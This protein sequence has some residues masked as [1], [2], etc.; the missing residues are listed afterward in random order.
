MANPLVRTPDALPA[1]TVLTVGVT[2]RV[3]P[4]D[5]LAGLARRFAAPPDAIRALNS[6]LD[7]GADA[8]LRAGAS[9][10]VIPRVCDA[11]CLYGRDCY[12]Y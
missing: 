2:Y 1:Y 5:T 3:R 11:P 9:L 8:G 6:D 4:G 7:W 10:C 12:V